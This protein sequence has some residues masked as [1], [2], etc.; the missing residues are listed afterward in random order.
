MADYKEQIFS[1]LQEKNLLPK[2]HGSYISCICPFC[3]KQDAFAY[4]DA[5][6]YGFLICNHRSRCGRRAQLKDVLGLS[7]P[8][9]EAR[10]AGYSE[11]FERHGLEMEGLLF[12]IGNEKEP[13]LLLGRNGDGVTYR[14]RLAWSQEEKKHR[15]LNP[16]GFKKEMAEFYHSLHP[17]QD[18]LY[19]FAGEWDWMKGS[20]DGLACTSSLFG[21]GYVPKHDQGFEVFIPY[22]E[23]RICLD[24]DIAGERGAAKL[25]N[26]LKK[27]FPTKKVGIIKL[28]LQENEGKDYCDYRKIHSLADFLAIAPIKVDIKKTAQEKKREKIASEYL[29]KQAETET[30]GDI[31]KTFRFSEDVAFV[32]AANGIF[33]SEVIKNPITGESFVSYVKICDDAV[34]ISDRAE[35]A[36]EEKNAYVTLTWSD[37]KREIIVPMS[38]LQAKYADKLAERGIRILSTEKAKAMTSYFELALRE[39]PTRTVYK[40]LG[41]YG[42]K[43]V[44]QGMVESR[45]ILPESRLHYDVTSDCNVEDGMQALKSCVKVVEDLAFLPLLL[46]SLLAPA[47]KKL[48]LTHK[49]SPFVIGHTGNYKTTLAKY[50]TAIYGQ[51]L[52]SNFMRFGEGATIA[53]IIKTCAIATDLPILI[54]NYKPNLA[55]GESDLLVII[56]SVIEGKD[57]L[58]LD[59]TGNFR[60]CDTLGAWPIITGE[61][62]IETDTSAIARCVEIEFRKTENAIEHLHIAAKHVKAL[63]AIGKAWIEWLKS[64]SGKDACCEVAK[65]RNEINLAWNARATEYGVQN[66]G[67]VADSLTCLDLAFEL[68]TKSSLFSWLSEYVFDFQILLEKILKG[69]AKSTLEA[70][71]GNRFLDALSELLASGSAMLA[72]NPQ[73]KPGNF[74]SLIGWDDEGK[75]TVYLLPKIALR[76]VRKLTEI[77]ITLNALYLQLEELGAIAEK[78]KDK[79]TIMKSL[80]GKKERVL[81]IKRKSLF[82]EE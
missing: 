32:V 82:R 77:R 35:I 66:S 63:P 48:G 3:G 58:R 43:F 14:K 70:R 64:Q 49:F 18:V 30:P 55:K 4:T 36:E 67:R 23:I 15:W 74:E 24:A 39:V 59:Q 27:K 28:P 7:F 52:F 9:D 8:K 41:W 1:L 26:C 25:A 22:E 69:M 57:K 54:D 50:A 34:I 47:S 31:I 42:E 79:T 56:Q 40:R 60:S 65:K 80:G 73:A 19:V 20:C 11:A 53:S 51:E 12:L 5:G 46:S 45:E 29:K 68:A 33:K 16:K 78:G 2:D 76:E 21:E 10:F 17:K 38:Y 75:D 6:F 13:S 71:E 81:A 72:P 62:S 44:V 37:G 61:A